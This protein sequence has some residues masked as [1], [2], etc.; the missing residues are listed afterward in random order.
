MKSYSIK[1][2]LQTVNAVQYLGK[3]DQ[4]P[5]LAPRALPSSSP[6]HPNE[7][8][9]F[10]GWPMRY[11]P[12]R[13][14]TAVL[15]PTSDGGVAAFPGDWIVEDGTGWLSVL[16]NANF[17]A[18]HEGVVSGV[19]VPQP[20]LPVPY[21]TLAP[22]IPVLRPL[23]PQPISVPAPVPVQTVNAVPVPV[24]VPTPVSTPVPVPVQHPVP[25]P[26]PVPTPI[27]E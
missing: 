3:S 18:K 14:L 25:V 13:H 19:I 7:Y 15:V 24:P 9:T 17:A 23:V 11:D 21:P 6:E 12:N 5:S 10:A 8:E 26:T 16:S 1:K 20:V 27:F 2:P 22:Q 4:T